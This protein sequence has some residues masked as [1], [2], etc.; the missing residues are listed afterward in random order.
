L[1][2][3]ITDEK[4]RLLN[5]IAC[6]SEGI[7]AILLLPLS[8]LHWC[9][10]ISSNSI[11]SASGNRIVKLLN[12]FIVIIGLVSAIFTIILGWDEFIRIATGFFVN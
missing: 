5:P 6:L 1:D 2:I 8:I 12:F 7:K 3:A 4:K 9:G 10:L 11:K